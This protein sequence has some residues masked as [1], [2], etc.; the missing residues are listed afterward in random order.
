MRSDRVQADAGNAA[1]VAVEGENRESVLNGQRRNY[2]VA[3]RYGSAF[4]AKLGREF[5]GESPSL[6]LHLQVVQTGE[7]LLKLLAVL[8]VP[9]AGEQFGQHHSARHRLRRA[10]EVLDYR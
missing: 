9:D 5:S 1:E 6:L 4:G 10:D 3:H 8:S 2:Q 7:R